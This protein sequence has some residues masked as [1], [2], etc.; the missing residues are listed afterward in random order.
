ML[1]PARALGLTP[2]SYPM[3][4]PWDAVHRLELSIYI[5]IYRLVTPSRVLSL[6]AIL[7]SKAHKATVCVIS[8]PAS[9]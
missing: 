9:A 7:C 5:Y 4:T 8:P 6:I 2:D 1:Q 3:S